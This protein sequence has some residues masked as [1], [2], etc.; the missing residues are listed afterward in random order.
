MTSSFI[1]AVKEK[2]KA[3]CK[4]SFDLC[5]EKAAHSTKHDQ[6]HETGPTQKSQLMT[7]REVRLKRHVTH[8]KM[9]LFPSQI[10]MLCM[11]KNYFYTAGSYGKQCD[12]FSLF[13]FLLKIQKHTQIHKIHNIQLLVGKLFQEITS[14]SLPYSRFCAHTASLASQ[15]HLFTHTHNAPQNKQKQEIEHYGLLFAGGLLL[16]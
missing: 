1:Y 9:R 5:V 16:P 4:D 8:E 15:L 12:I 2:S 14:L 13:L 10:I 11:H 6:P 3:Y 7:Y